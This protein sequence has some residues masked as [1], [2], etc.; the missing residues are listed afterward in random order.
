LQKEKQSLGEQR[1]RA[2]IRPIGESSS[3]LAV[4]DQGESSDS[5]RLH[6]LAVVS[7]ARF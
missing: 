1:S 5:L 2:L 3:H 7:T 6:K 4:F